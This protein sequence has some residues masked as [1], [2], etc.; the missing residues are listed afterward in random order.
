MEN[1]KEKGKLD[2]DLLD[3]VAGGASGDI[4]PKRFG[5]GDQVILRYYPEYGVGIVKNAS[6]VRGNWL[7]TVQ[8]DAGLMSADEHEFLPA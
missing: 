6:I 1:A 5:V 8:F 4:P 2:D 3:Q 7:Y